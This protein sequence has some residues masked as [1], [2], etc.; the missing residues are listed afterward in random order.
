MGKAALGLLLLVE[1]PHF[2]K[3]VVAPLANVLSGGAWVG[4]ARAAARMG[5][6]M[7]PFSVFS[8][9][10]LF[11]LLCC[12]SFFFFLVSFRI[13]WGT[14]VGWRVCTL[15]LIVAGEGRVGRC[16][17]VARLLSRA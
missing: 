2:E 6:G 12:C 10:F 1:Q 16:G 11:L 4:A 14:L 7:G 8:F 9:F 3:H 13:G 17:C 15:M 5:Y